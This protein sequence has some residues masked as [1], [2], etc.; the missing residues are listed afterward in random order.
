MM[1]T[2]GPRAITLIGLLVV[3]A[4]IAIL[5]GLMLP[6]IQNVRQT[7]ARIRCSNNLKQL[8]LAVHG[9]HDNN[10]RFPYSQWGLE[11]NVQYGGGANSRAWSW[12]A[13]TLPFVEQEQIYAAAGIPQQLLFSTGNTADPITIFLCPS[14]PN[15]VP[16]P[17]LDAGNLVGDPVG[18]TSY[19]GV[20]GSNWGADFD[21]F[22]SHQGFFQT[23]WPNK[24]V[25]GSYD[26]LDHG[27]GIFY[28]TN[29]MYPL[30]LVQITNGTSQTLMIGEDVQDANTWVSWPYANNAHGTCAIPLNV[31]PPSGGTYPPDQW[32][33]TWGFR[34]LHPNGA[35][36]ALADGSVHFVQNS[37]E[38]SNYRALST[39][40]GGEVVTLP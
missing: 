18:R 15:A 29:L 5:I 38:L 14:D 39:I 16:S 32:E 7:A 37:I 36:F 31:I 22:Q 25:N 30:T 26:G 13:R 27:D 33:N 17:R 35:N 9:F 20:S 1:T 19:K 23:D 34:S 10:Q 28:R 12:I 6:A 4:I 24:G 2:R 11:Y 3:I 21:S 8:A 40:N